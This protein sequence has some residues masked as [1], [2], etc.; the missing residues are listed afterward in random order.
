MELGPIK[1]SIPA[2]NHKPQD[3]TNGK[4]NIPQG[5]KMVYDTESLTTGFNE[6]DDQAETR[7]GERTETPESTQAP[8][9]NETNRQQKQIS[10]FD[11]IQHLIK[12]NL[13]PGCLN[14]PHAFAMSG[15]VLGLFLFVLVA[16]QGIYSMVLLVY[17]K[18]W[19]RANR[20]EKQ[21]LTSGQGMDE[22][23]E[24]Q[25]VATTAH[26]D[27][28]VTFMDVAYATHGRL[29]SVS[30]QIL[31]FVLQAGVCCVF[32]SLIA[33][34]L[35]ASIPSL[36]SELCVSLV[37][38][39]LL[40][41]VL[42]RDLK[43]LKWLSLGANCLMVTA[44]VTAS[45]SALWVL[46]GEEKNG[47]NDDGSANQQAKKWTTNPAAIAA[48]VSSMFYSF[49]GIGLVMPVENSFVGYKKSGVAEISST[50]GSSAQLEAPVSTE[51]EETQEELR[52]AGRTATFVSP[53]LLGAMSTVAGLFLLIG[54]TCGPAFPDIVDGSVTAYLTTKY[55]NSLWYQI[56]NASVMV[57]VFLTFPLQLT[58]AMEVLGDWFAPGC[59]PVCCSGTQSNGNTS[60]CCLGGG[61]LLSVRRRRQGGRHA[62][63]SQSDENEVEGEG[64]HDEGENGHGLTGD[65]IVTSPPLPPR[66]SCF[67]DYEW[68]FRRY[69]VVFGC[70]LVV[71]TVDDLGLLMSLF[72]A[73]GN[74]GLAAMPCIIHWKLVEQGIAPLNFLL[75]AVDVATIGMSLGVAIIG[76]AF[77][78]KE[79]LEK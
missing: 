9:F 63:I 68:I 17:C 49:E 43:E 53:V 67:G 57:A 1:S 66:N 25:A 64:F 52:I 29:G 72:G 70:A 18:Q 61:G 14:I 15:W 51:N 69:L 37:T 34:N 22:T 5:K 3:I 62:I 40:V 78:V 20:R 13:G 44:I 65:G 76:V 35:Q 6:L 4:R 27:E 11:A 75:L 79:I 50:S 45:V 12:G 73:L 7:S 33:T 10:E 26:E 2:I 16:I 60:S 38:F 24:N 42:V 31:L 59:D 36:D 21:R 48:F 56:V 41:V 28:I 23:E 39:M 32:L 71:L 54:A 58:P 77:S 47:D 19:I 74:T 8:G 46:F 30:V 55:P